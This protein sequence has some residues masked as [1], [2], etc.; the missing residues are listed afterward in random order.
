[1]QYCMYGSSK[2]QNNITIDACF[3][4]AANEIRYIGVSRKEVL[5]GRLSPLS[6]KSNA[7]K[8]RPVDVRNFEARVP[9]GM[10]HVTNERYRKLS[11]ERID[12]MHGSR[13]RCG[14]FTS[15]SWAQNIDAK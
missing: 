13:W 7:D 4:P 8:C 11:R 12:V 6:R 5:V 2:V 9:Y 15:Q 3:L 1:M 10:K 14:F